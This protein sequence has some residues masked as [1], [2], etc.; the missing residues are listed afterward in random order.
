MA[1]T[2]YFSSH[3]TIPPFSSHFQSSHVSSIFSGL[4]AFFHLFSPLIPLLF[5]LYFLSHTDSASCLQLVLF[6]FPFFFISSIE[7]PVAVIF[8]FYFLRGKKSLK[9]VLVESLILVG[10]Y[11]NKPKRL[12]HTG[13]DRNFGISFWFA[14][15][16]E[17]FCLFRPERNR[18][19]NNEYYYHK[20]RVLHLKEKKKKE[21]KATY[22]YYFLLS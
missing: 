12:K 11:R 13:I 15:R 8:S 18:I 9:C 4:G 2:I 3:L 5:L 21:K 20:T 10:I 6:F 1:Y 7:D 17:I 19:N 16:Y 14:N 22:L